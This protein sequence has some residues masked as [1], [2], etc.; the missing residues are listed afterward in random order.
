MR[1]LVLVMTRRSQKT[2]R[3]SHWLRTTASCNL[4]CSATPAAYNA[5]P[6]TV[7]PTHLC[8]GTIQSCGRDELLKRSQVQRAVLWLRTSCALR[9]TSTKRFWRTKMISLNQR[10]EPFVPLATCM[11]KSKLLCPK[12]SGREWKESKNG[13]P[14]DKHET[15]REKIARNTS[16]NAKKKE[17]THKF[18]QTNRGTLTG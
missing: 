5:K 7:A 1:L 14:D 16:T 15:T 18:F 6:M 9:N 2:P 13:G 10:R 4:Y 17:G 12:R 8:L 11:T 3:G